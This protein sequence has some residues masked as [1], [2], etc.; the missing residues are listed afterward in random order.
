M[1]KPIPSAMGMKASGLTNPF[2]GRR[3]RSSDTFFKRRLHAYAGFEFL[4]ELVEEPIDNDR[5]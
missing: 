4:G 5:N 2:P 3:Q 1:L